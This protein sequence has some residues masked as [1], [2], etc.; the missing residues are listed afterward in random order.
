[1]SRIITYPSIVESNTNYKALIVDIGEE[2][3]KR[4]ELF[5]QITFRDFDVYL[6]DGN[7]DDLQWL[8]H[9]TEDC[10]AVLINNLSSVSITSAIRY[11]QECD[12]VDPL[13]YFEQ[14]DVDNN[15]EITV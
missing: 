4:L 7:S 8:S 13:A 2:D 11:G 15:K 6:Y 14:I 3:R 1:M 9:I 12:L 10:S 5:L